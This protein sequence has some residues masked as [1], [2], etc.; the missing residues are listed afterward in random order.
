MEPSLAEVDL[1]EGGRYRL[2]MR[3]TESGAEHTVGGEY[4]EIRR[5]ERIVFTW[6]WE[7][8]PQMATDTLVEV[9]FLEDGDGT[10]VVLKHTGFTSE[11]LR[12]QHAHGWTGCLDNLERRVFS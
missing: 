5:P 8:N 6:T 1:R 4:R 3:D 10:E 12:D 7:E 2:G 9:D 11:E